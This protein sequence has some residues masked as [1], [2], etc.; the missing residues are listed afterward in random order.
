M[1]RVTWCQAIP[2][3]HKQEKFSHAPARR[4]DDKT[5]ASVFWD[6]RCAV[7]PPREKFFVILP[8]QISGGC[9]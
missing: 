1:S 9:R 2:Q 6:F 8:K 7:A 4:R 5:V 3:M